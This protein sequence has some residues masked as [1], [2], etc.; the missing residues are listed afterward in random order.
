M[1]ET[2]L[3]PYVICH[4]RDSFLFGSVF[5][6]VRAWP[7]GGENQFDDVRVDVT[8]RYIYRST[9]LAHT[10]TTQGPAKKDNKFSIETID[11]SKHVN[12]M[13]PSCTLRILEERG[14]GHTFFNDF[15]CVTRSRSVDARVSY[16]VDNET[17]S[18]S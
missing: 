8:E 17:T 3:R 13:T 11:L 10:L 14:A 7:T 12:S 1:S 18:A 9:R 4:K 5:V 16:E 2:L 15:V 6:N